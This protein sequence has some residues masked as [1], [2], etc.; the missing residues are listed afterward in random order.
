MLT[1]VVVPASLAYLSRTA[2]EVNEV[3]KLVKTLTLGPRSMR[4]TDAAASAAH[5]VS[6]KTGSISVG[7]A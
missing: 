4:T 3:K 7:C 6:L 2:D 5:S 1:M